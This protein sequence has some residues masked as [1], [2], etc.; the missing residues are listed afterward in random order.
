MNRHI[1]KR[2]VQNAGLT[3][4]ELAN[5]SGIAQT[6]INRL[7]NGATPDPR[8]STLLPLAKYFNITIGQLLGEEPLFID[9]DKLKLIKINKVPLFSWE[10]VISYQKLMGTLTIETWNNWVIANADISDQ[11]YALSVHQRSLSP[12]FPYNTTLIVDQRQKIQDNDY[13]IIYR[14]GG[15]T[16]SVK[17]VV[18]IGDERWLLDPNKNVGAML[19]TESHICCG[20]I[21]QAQ[22][23]FTAEN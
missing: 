1:L 14:E 7:M 19:F 17:K 9:G 20:V 11:A 22:I 10:E 8:T 12:V 13:V 2:L 3:E 21:I 6:T 15:N 5:K 4:V 18:I 16:T 23:P